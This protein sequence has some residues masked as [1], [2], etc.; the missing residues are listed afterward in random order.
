MKKHR[1]I[2]PLLA[3]GTLLL[4]ASESNT[5]SYREN[6][7]QA[8]NKPWIESHTIPDDRGAIDS[9]TEVGDLY[10]DNAKA[11]IKRLLEKQQRTADEERIVAYYKSYIDMKGRNAKGITPLKP[12][13]EQIDALRTQEDLTTLLVEWS[14]KGLPVPYGFGSQQDPYDATRYLLAMGQSGMGLQKKYYDDNSSASIKKRKNYTKYLRDVLTLAGVTDVNRTVAN[15]MKLETALAK[16]AFSVIEMRDPKKTINIMDY[17]TLKKMLPAL[18]VAR[19]FKRLGYPK[20]LKINMLTPRYFQSLNTLLQTVP[21]EVW[22]DYLRARLLS[23]FAASLSE[24]FVQAGLRYGIAEGMSTKLE[25]LEVRAIRRIDA[26]ALNFLFGK[27]YVETY[28]NEAIKK[29]V[30]TILEAIL[31]SYREAIAA[32][33]RFSPETKKTALQKIEKMDFRIAYPTKWHDYSGVTL[34]EDDLVGNLLALQRYSIARDTQKL[35]RGTVDKEMWE[36]LPPQEVNA[37]YSASDN[38]F[39]LLSGI[40]NPPFFD[41][42]ASDAANY[43]GIGLAI[44]HEIGHAFDRRG[45]QFDENGA[46]RNWWTPKDLAAFEALNKKLI[47]QANAYEIV[48]GVHANGKLQV[49]EIAADLSG[50]EIALQAYLNTLKEDNASKAQGMREFFIQYAKAWHAKMRPQV[51]IMLN[52]SDANPVPEYRINGTVRNMEA[53]YQAFGVKPSDGMYLPPKERVKFWQ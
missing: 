32:T 16:G 5:T 22:K 4:S 8:V 21:I 51:L 20:T 2:L 28:F 36:G 13:L 43:G 44:G 47:A 26:S 37:Y 46:F 38:R 39:I 35:I 17:G 12:M 40:L 6:F 30:E 25:P 42:N 15:A 24:P 41:M 10:L 52:D 9:F 1:Y 19:L 23:G 29:K 34:K 18:D 33:P 31:Q 50:A 7:Y 3:A 14:E 27:L 49:T 11:L 53:F 45:A 48:P